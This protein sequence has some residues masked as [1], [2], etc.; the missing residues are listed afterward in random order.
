MRQM[1]IP[2]LA[3]KLDETE[4]TYGQVHPQVR[5]SRASSAGAPWLFSLSS[6]DRAYRFRMTVD[7]S[8]TRK[9][10]VSRTC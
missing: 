9:H 10:G 1:S 5:H 3:R 2:G 7:L 8:G 4:S 6:N